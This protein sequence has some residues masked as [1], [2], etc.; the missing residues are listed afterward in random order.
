MVLTLEREYIFEPTEK[1]K[2]YNGYFGRPYKKKEKQNLCSRSSVSTEMRGVKKVTVKC[3]KMSVRL[4]QNMVQKHRVFTFRRK[5]VLAF[6]NSGHN[7]LIC[8]E[9]EY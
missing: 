2:R 8:L 5:E 9:R 7:F 6:A 3:T 4:C 1:R